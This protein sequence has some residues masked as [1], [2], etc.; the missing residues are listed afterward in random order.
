MF[1]YPTV[2]VLTVTSGDSLSAS[3]S[4]GSSQ[5]TRLLDKR[6]TR[7][8]SLVNGSLLWSMNYTTS[9]IY[10][11]RLLLWAYHQQRLHSYFWHSYACTEDRLRNYS[12]ESLRAP[13]NILC[14][15]PLT[16]STHSTY[17]LRSYARA[18]HASATRKNR[19]QFITG[20]CHRQPS[21]KSLAI[22]HTRCGKNAYL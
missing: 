6:F 9:K 22:F 8:S 12:F 5:Y 3:N 1:T 7:N 17:T 15:S 20:L 14:W 10:S 4:V 2:S 11:C 21:N 16:Y 19:A 13:Y 18:E